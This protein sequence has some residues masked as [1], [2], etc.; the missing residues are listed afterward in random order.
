MKKWV[1]EGTNLQ[2]LLFS[3]FFF[4]ELYQFFA[5]EMGIAMQGEETG[6]WEGRVG[7]EIQKS[8][9][10]IGEIHSKADWA[11]PLQWN[12]WVRKRADGKGGRGSCRDKEIDQSRERED[13][14]DYLRLLR[15]RRRIGAGEEELEDLGHG[16]F[17]REG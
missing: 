12:R 6:D 11:A 13:G 8:E 3:F 16:F 5:P 10:G 4:L 9:M 17:E 14:R 15:D 7:S 1:A 2:F